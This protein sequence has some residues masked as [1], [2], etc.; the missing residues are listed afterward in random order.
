MGEVAVDVED[1]GAIVFGVN[2]MIVPELVVESAS[3]DGPSCG[4]GYSLCSDSVAPFG[5]CI[6]SSIG[7]SIGT[8]AFSHCSGVGTIDVFRRFQI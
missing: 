6:G 2:D 1:G 7:S 4:S 5:G 3:H 8:N